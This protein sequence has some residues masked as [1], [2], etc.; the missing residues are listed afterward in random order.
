M[1]LKFFVTLALILCLSCLIPF[2]TEASGS[3]RVV[4]K[5]TGSW[6]YSHTVYKSTVETKD[7]KTFGIGAASF[8]I[9][10]IKSTPV[11]AIA[12]GFASV[13]SSK[14]KSTKVYLKF[15]V[16]HKNNKYVNRTKAVLTVYKDK[17]MK[18]KIGGSSTQ[19]LYTIKKY[20]TVSKKQAEK[21]KRK[22][23]LFA[24]GGY[25]L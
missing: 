9:G 10:K 21:M 15:K 20:K 7:A 5:P 19:Y 8:L 2:S 14:I 24:I 23:Q 16:Y 12:S 13:W 3:V 4:P 6:K 22:K 11:G 25:V 18:H 1:K 17:K